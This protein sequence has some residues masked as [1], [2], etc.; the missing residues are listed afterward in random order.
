MRNETCIREERDAD[1]DRI[2][3]IHDAAFGGDAEGRL[4][5]RL[6]TGGLI[7]ASIVGV[8]DDAVIANV[9]FSRIVM[10]TPSETVNAVALA[11]VAV[12]PAYQRRGFGSKVIAYGLRLCAERGYAAAFVLGDPEYYSRFGFSSEAAKAVFSKYSHIGNAWMAIRLGV[13]P[14]SWR[15]ARVDYPNAFSIVD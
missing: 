5:D 15:E 4:I 6:R 12:M 9:V 1:T 13:A 2:R 10:T 8:A 14:I 7:V 11:P 3:A